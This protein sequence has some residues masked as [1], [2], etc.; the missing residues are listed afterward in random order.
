MKSRDEH[1]FGPGPKRILALDGGGVRGLATLGLLLKVET[2]LRNRMPPDKQGSFRLCDYFDLIGGTSTGGIIATLLALGYE[3][4]D[5]VTLYRDMAP[6]VFGKARWFQGVQSKFDSK[7]LRRSVNRTLSD[8]LKRAGRNPKDLSVLRLNTD[9]LRTGLALVTKR[10]DTGAVWVLTNNPK[11]KYW[12]P[13]SNLWAKHF[14]QLKRKRDFYPNS[15]YPLATIIQASAS[16][17]FYLDGVALEISPKEYGYFLDGGV[18]PFNNP[19]QEL[20]LMA[21]LKAHGP[22]WNDDNVSP[23]GFAWDTGA[24]RLFML[25]LGTGTW[26]ERMDG[27]KF[28]KMWTVNQAKAALLSIIDDASLAGTTWMQALSENPRASVINGSL[29]EMHHLR[30]VREPLLSFRR[31][32]PRLEDDWLRA[33]DAKLAFTEGE[34]AKTREIDHSAKANLDRL[35]DIGTCCGERDICDEDFAPAFDLEDMNK[36]EL[37]SATAARV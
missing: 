10:I 15:D 5:I 27:A 11:T 12:D 7:A 21:T 2:L 26:R 20:F 8:C 37:A 14:E 13:T 36:K 32:S 17:P 28:Q 18:S 35:M 6:N 25:S 4:K 29:E 9:L 31:I 22:G 33:L 30:I 23:H 3:V 19:S 24:D 34:L 1:L 16:A